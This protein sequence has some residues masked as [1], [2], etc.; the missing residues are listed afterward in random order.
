MT[1]N[2][3]CATQT[4]THTYYRFPCA[5]RSLG[6]AS[7]VELDRAQEC[8][9]ATVR[10]RCD[11]EPAVVAEVLIRVKHAGVDHLAHE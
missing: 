8:A 3:E 11:D 1:S 9:V 5:C 4:Q 7:Q 2:H 6:R 10:E